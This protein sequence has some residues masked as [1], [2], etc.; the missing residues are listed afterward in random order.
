M[1]RY[2][3]WYTR[4]VLTIIAG[5]LAWNTLAKLH[6]ATVHA[7]STQYGVEVITANAKTNLPFKHWASMP[8]PPE[9]AAAIN[10]VA[11]G[12]ELVT[13]IWLEPSDKYVA[14]FKQ[15]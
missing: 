11:K 4:A 15:S 1:M 10:G 13:V 9:F 12:C 3:D 5:L 6:P 8:F 7:Q 14:V 2:A